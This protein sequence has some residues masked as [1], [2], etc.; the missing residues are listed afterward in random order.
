MAQSDKRRNWSWEED[1]VLLIQAAMDRPF[2]A[3]KG[4]LTKA[5]QAMADTMMSCDHFTRVVDGRKVQ[6][7]FSALVEEHRR[8]DKALARV[9]APMK[10]KHILLDDVVALLDDARDVASQ[11]TSNNVVEKEKAE[12]GALLVRD[13]A[14]RTMKRRNENDPDELKKKPALDNRRNSLA[15]AIEAE[16]ERELAVREKELLFQQFKLESEIKQRELDREERKAEREHQILLARI[17]NEKMLGMF[18]AIAESKK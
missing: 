4:Q 10:K 8:F 1:K 17:D 16:S 5:W 2:G 9:P 12:Q 11:K 13:M 18:K 7:R 3:E 14:M 6:N 15:A